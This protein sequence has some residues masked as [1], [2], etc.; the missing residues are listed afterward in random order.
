MRIIAV[1]VVSIIFL[2]IS[3]HLHASDLKKNIHNNAESN[4]TMIIQEVEKNFGE[5]EKILA[6]KINKKFIEGEYSVVENDEDYLL[7]VKIIDMEI[8]SSFENPV[9]KKVQVSCANQ[10]GI[11]FQFLFDQKGRGFFVKN[12]DKISL[13][14]FKKA[15]N[16][17]KKF[18]KN[19]L[20]ANDY[21]FKLK[22]SFPS[23]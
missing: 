12:I 13:V 22:I 14:I 4:P 8:Y 11:V 21:R 6:S 15:D 10:D 1:F 5:F 7:T 16:F 23:I 18:K 17:F 19:K 20:Y 9:I 2:M 3:G